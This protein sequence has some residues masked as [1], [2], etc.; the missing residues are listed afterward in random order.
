MF[1]QI[2]TKTCKN[3]KQTLQYLWSM[4]DLVYNQTERLAS[5]FKE[6]H[7]QQAY[8]FGSATSSDFS[9][10]SDIDILV[11]FSDDINLLDY[12][13]NYFDLK[14]KLEVLF[15]RNVDLVSS[16]S[17][18]NPVLIESINKSKMRLYAA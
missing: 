18:K 14:D 7:V 2:S 11:N 6:H 3:E 15:G 10:A 12:A 17:L 16:R 5:I 9:S 4:I 1:F 8:L 13:D